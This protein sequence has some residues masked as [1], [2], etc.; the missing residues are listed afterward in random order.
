MIFPP[1]A[2][3]IGIWNICCG[4][5]SFSFFNHHAAACLGPVAMHQHGERIDGSALTRI[6][7]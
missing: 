1:I 4:M 6:D 3:W 5:S 2:A 7:I